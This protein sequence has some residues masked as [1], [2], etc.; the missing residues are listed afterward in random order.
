MRDDELFE[1]EEV[2]DEQ[3]AVCWRDNNRACGTDCVA[4]DDRAM[5][6]ERFKPCLLLN[7]QRQQANS[8]GK[9]SAAASKIFEIVEKVDDKATE[10][11]VKKRE[12]EEYAQKIKE[13]PSPPEIKT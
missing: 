6:D 8:L 2:A 12:A 13:M 9:L 3:L 10:S 5:E 11:L 4:Y 7:I 1:P